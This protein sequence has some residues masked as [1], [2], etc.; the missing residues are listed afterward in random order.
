MKFSNLK[1]SNLVKYL[2]TGGVALVVVLFFIPK[3]TRIFISDMYNEY[4]S[5]LGT[6]MFIFIIAVIYFLG[7]LIFGVRLCLSLL[8]AFNKW[9]YKNNS[10]NKFIYEFILILCP[11]VRF[12]VNHMAKKLS[13]SSNLNFYLPNWIYLVKHPQRLLD[14]MVDYTFKVAGEDIDDEMRYMNETAVTLMFIFS[15]TIPFLINYIVCF[16]VSWIIFIPFVVLYGLLCVLSYIFAVKFL[17]KLGNMEKVCENEKIMSNLPFQ[18]NELPT[19]YVL[20]RTT[21]RQKRSN[22]CLKDALNSVAKQDYPNIK[23]IVLDDVDETEKSKTQDIIV[24]SKRNHNNLSISYD[25]HQCGGPAGAAYYIREIFLRVASERDIAIM[26]DDDDTLNYSSAI[27]DI[28]LHMYK[29]KADICLCSFEV[30]ENLNLNICNKGGKTHNKIVE[31]LE[32]EARVFDE[33]IVMISSIGWTKVYKYSQIEKYNN[34]ILKTKLKEKEEAKVLYEKLARY[35]DFPDILVLSSSVDGKLPILT[36][37]SRPTHNY[38]KRKGGIT[39]TPN[40]ND[41]KIARPQ[42]LVLTLNL[43][44]NSDK[45]NW[46]ITSENV[47]N[48][49]RF[50]LFKTLQISNI[51]MGYKKKFIEGDKDLSDFGK[52]KANYFYKILCNCIEEEVKDIHLLN[53]YL[54]LFLGDQTFYE[55][56][57]KSEMKYLVKKA[58]EFM[59]NENKDDIDI[60]DLKYF[61]EKEKD[62]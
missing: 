15:L 62:L 60:D 20:I 27:S 11:F 54:K 34:F 42:F 10:L 37:L 22:D 44:L 24:E 50:V 45:E 19:V 61:Y 35:E 7:V 53:K 38:T 48:I 28:V 13:I 43:A 55:K 5:A 6:I 41:F 8:I 12:D 14:C 23:I 4:S 52:L 40:I 36:G 47:L 59:Y 39:T 16:D 31:K 9:L 1:F 17:T 26:L 2:F 25:K 30:V 3:E 49:V 57:E 46:N 32:R 29:Y 56:N 21:D 33:S 18:L 51:L 58:L